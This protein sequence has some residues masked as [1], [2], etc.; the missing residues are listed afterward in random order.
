MAKKKQ[1]PV[2]SG[3]LK[4]VDAGGAKRHRKTRTKAKKTIPGESKVKQYIHEKEKR[5]NNPPVGLVT[6]ESDIDLPAKKYSFAPP[7]DPQLEWSGK[8]ELG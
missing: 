3:G 6:P 2:K 1:R 8:A 7:L 5:V 4:S